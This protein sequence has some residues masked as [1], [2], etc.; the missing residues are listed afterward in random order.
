MRAFFVASALLGAIAVAGAAA[1]GGLQ[2]VTAP[3]AEALNIPSGEVT[4]GTVQIPRRVMADG[5][6]LPA[7]T[8]EL[9]VTAQTS[10]GGAGQLEELS[11]WVE[12]RQ[13][14]QVRGRELASIVPQSE[15]KQVAEGGM[16][17]PGSVRVD[18]I[19]PNDYLRIWANHQGA[20]FLIHLP[21]G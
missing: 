14:G 1:G 7:G 18:M 21:V 15:I 17:G 2:Q 20:H 10:S 11:R 9:R 4:L 5:K 19:K 13:K 8:Y 12:F 3:G 6:P 16:P